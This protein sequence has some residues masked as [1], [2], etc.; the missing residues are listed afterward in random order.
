MKSCSTYELEK[1]GLVQN[2]KRGLARRGQ[3][4]DSPPH[5]TGSPNSY[6]KPYPLKVALFADRTPRR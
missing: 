5:K 2:K 3:V 4:L 6:L 1:E